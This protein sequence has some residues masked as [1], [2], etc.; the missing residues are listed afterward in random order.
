MNITSTRDAGVDRLKIVIYGPAGAGKTRLAATTGDPSAT[1]IVSAE[2]GLLSLRGE[3]IAV[4]EVKSLAELRAVYAYL[5]KGDHPYRWVIVDSISEIAEVCLGEEKRSAKDPRAAYGQM[6]EVVVGTLR[7]FRDLPCHVVFTAKQDRTQTE[8]GAM[9][10]GPSMPGKQLGPAVGY[11]VDE[12]WALRVTKGDDG[13]LIRSLQTGP[14]GVYDAKDRSGSLQHHEPADLSAVA[15]KILGAA[16]RAAPAA[17][18][19]APKPAPVAAAPAPSVTL[20]DIDDTPDDFIRA[21]FG[22]P[23]DV[24]ITRATFDVGRI[25]AVRDAWD[26]QKGASW[27]EKMSS[28]TNEEAA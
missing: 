27:R 6:A 23:P 25:A 11:L 26:G 22:I 16:K 21:T 20:A 4:A 7:A 3:D 5:R 8:G 2:A 10:Y 9:L 13:A 1:I 28:N 19:P 12:M 24:T 18:A 15:A 14:D 17:K